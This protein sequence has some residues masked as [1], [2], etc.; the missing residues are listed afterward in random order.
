MENN[1]TPALVAIS[2]KYLLA[3]YIILPILFLVFLGDI[4]LFNSALLPYMGLTS[5]VLPLYL[6][7]FE[8]PHI[9]ASFFGFADKEYVTHYK[10]QLLLYLPLL[11]IAT[12]I[13]LYVNFA[14]GVTL[15][16]VGTVWHG[17]KQQT[18]IAL[19]LGARP[20][21]LHTAWTLI[22]V[23]ITSLAYI[24]YI[25]P[26]VVPNFIVPLISPIIFGGII[27]LIVITILKM[28]Q[29]APKVRLYILCVSSLFFFSYAFILTGYIFFAF[30]AVRFIHDL[31]AFAFYTTHDQNRNTVERKNL[32]Y[33]LFTA[34]PLPVLIL[35]P[36]LA[37]LFAYIT[38]V[39][40]DG[41][42]IGYVILVLMGMSHYYLESV[43]WKRDTPHRKY[44]KVV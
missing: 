11:L 27:S 14:L 43:M 22:P 19:I 41:L 18:G 25:V 5:M 26:E 39:T 42:A 13:L 1:S 3:V 12:S 10:K 21:W 29:S 6:L 32:F 2:K 16:L 28:W 15:Y 7:F 33:R 24:Y 37:V 40:T 23:V 38:R 17:L 20:G 31:S 34:V 30:F 4:F 44:I 35:T 9:I 36:A 8:L